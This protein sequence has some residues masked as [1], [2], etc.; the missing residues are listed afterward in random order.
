[1]GITLASPVQKFSASSSNNETQNRLYAHR[2]PSNEG[3]HE[4]TSIRPMLTA[5][6]STATKTADTAPNPQTTNYKC[7]SN[8]YLMQCKI[9]ENESGNNIN[10]FI[11]DRNKA[12]TIQ[13]TV[14]N[15]Q[16]KAYLTATHCCQMTN[17]Q[18]L[19]RKPTIYYGKP[20]IGERYSKWCTT[21]PRPGH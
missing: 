11:T 8:H 12:Y 6:K 2:Q 10:R 1:M 7:S 13:N 17:S 21:L 19:N 4:W 18:Y 9:S 5:L 3:G 20:I 15:E 14:T 16:L